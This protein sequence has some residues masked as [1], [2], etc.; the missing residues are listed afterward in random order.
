MRAAELASLAPWAERAE[1]TYVAR[2][3]GRAAPSP[4]PL[5]TS[6]SAAA[7]AVAPAA[8]ACAVAARY[9]AVGTP[10]SL[11]VLSDDPERAHVLALAHQVWHRPSELRWSVAGGGGDELVRVRG[12]REVPVAEALTADIV[13]VDLPLTLELSQVRRGSHLALVRGSAEPALLAR[14]VCAGERADLTI[15]ELAAGLRDGRQLDE[16]T[17]LL[18]ADDLAIAS[19]ALAG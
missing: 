8:V 18:L 4:L 3:L 17:L 5:P 6:W 19:S 14:A 13:C 9:L 1:A 12:G 11:S 15:G 2:A 10:R 16:L 7:R